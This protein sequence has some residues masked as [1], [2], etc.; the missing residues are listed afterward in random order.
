MKKQF[1]LLFLSISFLFTASCYNDD[2]LK[3]ELFS[4]NSVDFLYSSSDGISN[5][6][7]GLYSINRE[8]SQGD[9]LNGAATLVLQAKS[10]LSAGV[11]GEIS[12]FSNCFWG[13]GI[14]EDWGGNTVYASFW[15]KNYKIIDIT[16]SIINGG[17]ELI[18]AGDSSEA[19]L[20]NIAEAK[21]FRAHAYFTLYRMFKNIYINSS[22]TTPENAFDKPTEPSKKEDIFDLIRQ[23]LK[24][25]SDN[26][27]YS[28]TQFGRWNKGAVDHVRAKV[29]MWHGDDVID[30]EGTTGYEAAAS[31]VDELIAD[32]GYDLVGSDEVFAGELNHSETLFAINFEK[33][34]IGGGVFHAMNWVTVARYSVEPGLK[35]SIDNGGAGFGFMGLNPYAVDLLNENPD[36]NRIGSYY[37]FEYLYNDPETLPAGKSIG[38]PLDTY[39]RDGADDFEF[40]N[41]FIHQNPSVLKFLDSSVEANDREHYKNIMVYRLAETYLIGAE[42]HLEEGN[43]AKALEYLNKIRERAGIDLATTVTIETIFEE[44]A[45]ELAFE[46]QRWYSLKRKG[47]LYNY[48]MDHMNSDLLNEYYD[49][50]HYNPKDEL[51]PYMVNFKIP[52]QIK[53]LLGTEYPQNTG[54]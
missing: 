15:A 51:E 50:A 17:E 14:G 28:V 13:C 34:T 52:D 38:D 37:I 8:F 20:Q 7:V 29:E 49:T 32:G 41:Y 24:F 54:Y 3:D 18:E 30:D 11:D 26:L 9:F 19:L 31:I 53:E 27:A 25:A 33:N 43:T 39:D 6:V 10:D 16:N 4:N 45:R 48:L 47:L 2:F 40:K 1:R 5:A 21:V 12:L 42:A 22:I 36:D 46:G 44:R 23:D 35:Q